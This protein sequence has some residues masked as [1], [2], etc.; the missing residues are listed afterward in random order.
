M[1]DAIAEAKRRQLEA[2]WKAWG[3]ETTTRS[4]ASPDAKPAEPQPIQA[5]P[6]ITGQEAADAWFGPGQPRPAGAP[7][8]GGRRYDYPS[9]VNVTWQPRTNEPSS[10]GISFQ[11]LRQ[12]A[13]GCTLLRLVIENRKNALCA[14]G[15]HFR[16][17]EEGDKDAEDAEVKAVTEFFRSPDKNHGYRTWMGMLL[18]EA[19][20]TDAT[21]IYRR[22]AAD[23]KSVYSLDPIDGATITPQVDAYGKR[24]LP[25]GPAYT[26]VLKGTPAR[27]F[28]ADEMVQSVKSPRVWKLYGL[29]VTEMVLG[30]AAAAIERDHTR[31]TKYTDGSWPTA[32]LKSPVDWPPAKLAEFSGF[33][34]GILSGNTREKSRVHMVPGDVIQMNADVLKDEFDEWL[35]RIIAFAMGMSPQALVKEINRATAETSRQI[36]IEEGLETWK[37]WWK[38]LMN[39]LV[40]HMLGYPRI[41]FVWDEDSRSTT[42]ETADRDA[43]QIQWGMKDLDDA[44]KEGGKN[45]I[46]LGPIIVAPGGAIYSVAALVAA[47]KGGEPAKPLTAQLPAPALLPPGEDDEG[48][49]GRMTRRVRRKKKI[50]LAP[51]RSGK[52]A[53]ALDRAESKL[54]ALSLDRLTAVKDAALQAIKTIPDSVFEAQTQRAAVPPGLLAT[55][56]AAIEDIGFAVVQG[57]VALLLVDMGQ[58]EAEAALGQIIV[59]SEN[60]DAMLRVDEAVV[61][62]SRDHAA[63]LV[64]RLDQT[65]RDGRTETITNAFRNGLTRNELAEVIETD[66]KMSEDRAQMIAQTEM[67]GAA[68]QADL[69]GWQESG[70]VSRKVWLLS[71]DHPELDECDDNAEQGEIPVAMPFSDG[72]MTHPAHPR[73]ICSV[74]AVVEGLD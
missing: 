72:S 56:I 58:V 17:L 19:F 68:G 34:N 67:S 70:V 48:D 28:T 57:D 55:V 23:G 18:E 14:R 37:I 39:H 47:Q 64:T 62:W 35:A 8:T 41:E 65:R 73:C 71:A 50:L 30:I 1:P 10:A 4:A 32:F 59:A 42:K 3:R 24:P 20:V 74:A 31:L 33:L 40:Q 43:V 5:Q 52:I 44:R 11:L 63:A 22:L 53:D 61:S 36:S 27:P 9:L 13:D 12:F 66:F 15:Y 16:T 49:D 25:P 38:D 21:T 6:N 7:D 54:Q 60:P 46:G 51:R 45:P 2:R 26:Q 29:S 69:I